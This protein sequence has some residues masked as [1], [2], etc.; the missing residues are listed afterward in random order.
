VTF[1]NDHYDLLLGQDGLFARKISA[2]AKGL[3]D[4]LGT[5][6]ASD[7]MDF[8]ISD[9][10]RNLF[11]FL[12]GRGRIG[13]RFAPRFWEAETTLG[14]GR[15]LMIIACKKWHVAKRLVAAISHHTNTPALEYLFNE[16]DTPLPDLGGIETSLSKRGRHRRALMR[17]LFDNYETDRLVI[18]LD[19]SSIDL[20]AD[21][22]TD[23]ARVRLLEIECSFDDDYLIGHAKRVGL[24]GANTSSETLA[25]LLP[26]IRHDFIHERDAIRDAQFTNASLIK[27]SASDDQNAVALSQFLSVSPQ[28]AQSLAET[29]Y[30]FAD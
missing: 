7:R 20:M 1:Y 29:P 21:F 14:R 4:G 28:V 16:D 2:E 17:M 25:R 19:T 23:R 6:Y 22:Y 18:C 3:R 24:A 26:T 10:G 9:E 12:T 8:T 15:E 27:E 30:L 11:Q 5:S 13:R